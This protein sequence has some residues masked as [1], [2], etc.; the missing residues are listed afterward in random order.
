MPGARS[1]IACD[2]P[3]REPVAVARGPFASLAFVLTVTVVYSA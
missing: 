3:A 1:P 2:G